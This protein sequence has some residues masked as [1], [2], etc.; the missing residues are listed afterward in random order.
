M[1][2]DLL[3]LESKFKDEFDPYC[4]ILNERN[5]NTPEPIYLAVNTHSLGFIQDVTFLDCESKYLQHILKCYLT[6]RIYLVKIMYGD[7]NL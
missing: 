1:G 7:S 3:R 5:I 6:V 4:H 2:M